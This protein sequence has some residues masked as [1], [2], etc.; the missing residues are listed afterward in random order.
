MSDAV[1]ACEHNGSVGAPQRVRRCKH[2]RLVSCAACY[3]PPLTES[4][5]SDRG[6]TFEHRR[7]RRCAYLAWGFE[8]PRE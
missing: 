4:S 1:G 6:R 8:S 7:G 5:Q 2:K 3:P